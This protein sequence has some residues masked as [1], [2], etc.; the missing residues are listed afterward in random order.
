MAS[1]VLE[2]NCA[3]QGDSKLEYCKTVACKEYDT[4][5]ADWVPCLEECDKSS[6]AK[7]TAAVEAV[8]KIK[9]SSVEY[10]SSYGYLRTGE[11][12]LTHLNGGTTAPI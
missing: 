11:T 12:Y 1:V 3:P 7:V 9:V 2:G 10:C 6:D 4:G 8:A 5:D